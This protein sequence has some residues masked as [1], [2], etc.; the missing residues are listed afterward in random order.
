MKRPVARKLQLDKNKQKRKKELVKELWHGTEELLDNPVFVGK[1]LKGKIH[2]SCPMCA[3]KTKKD[4]VKI[5]EKRRIKEPQ[6]EEMVELMDSL[7]KPVEFKPEWIDVWEVYK[8]NRVIIFRWV[9]N[10][11]GFGELVVDVN[12]LD[13]IDDEGM[14]IEFSNAVIEIGFKNHGE[15][16]CKK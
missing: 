15:Y 12:T 5:S 16:L 6:K 2:C 11:I 1:L 3:T 4:G 10:H 14:G 7:K 9:A 8:D 13:L